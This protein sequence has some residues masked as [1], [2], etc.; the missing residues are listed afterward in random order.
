MG[1][2]AC[3]TIERE[4]RN[5]RKQRRG[6]TIEPSGAGKQRGPAGGRPAFDEQPFAKHRLRNHSRVA[7]SGPARLPV[8]T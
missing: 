2:P 6:E 4:A 3:L 8:T 7:N 5:H 1:P